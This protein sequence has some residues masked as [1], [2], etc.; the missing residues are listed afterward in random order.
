MQSVIMPKV[1][2]IAGPNGAGKS[3]VAR[4]VLRNALLVNDFVNADAIAAG[5]SA[6]FPE[7]VAVAAGRV[8][9][10][11]IGE[12]ARE[13]RDFAFETTLASRTFAPWLRKLQSQGYRFD[14]V[15]LWLATAELAVARV[16][17]RV[18]RGGHAVADDI[19]RRRYDRGL[20][21]FLGIY[22]G[23]ADSWLMVDNSAR[24]RLVAKRAL[25]RDVRVFRAEERSATRAD[26]SGEVRTKAELKATSVA[27]ELLQDRSFAAI[28]NA[29]QEA[30]R[31]HKRAGNPIAEW[32]D[33]RV[34]L[35]PSEQIED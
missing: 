17:E 24:P 13:R 23:F 14:L 33:G 6:F 12:L 32:K 31:D 2:V 21:N 29:V 10:K 18:R 25:G 28:G 5:L 22:G 1:V 26:E 30:I 19:V 16:G 11:R 35:V 15:Y 8:M 4:A 3:T 34:V 7:A 9:L 20:I 27:E